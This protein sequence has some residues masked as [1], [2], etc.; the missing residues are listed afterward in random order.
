MNDTSH[1]TSQLLL[2]LG[3]LPSS[4]ESKSPARLSSESLQSALNETLQE[5]LNGLGS[6]IYSGAW[7]PHTTPAGRLISRLRVSARRTSDSAHSSELSGWPTPCAS[8]N[9]D[10]GKWDDPAIQRRMEIGKSIELSM[11]VGVAGWPT[12]KARDHKGGYQGGR[13][14]DGKVSLDTL[15]VAGQLA[16]WPTPIKQDAASS[17]RTTTDG[18]KWQSDHRLSACHT[19]L[20]AA[21]LAGWAT[22]AASN[23]E[24]GGSIRQAM[25]EVRPSGHHPAKPLEHMAQLVNL[26]TVNGPARLTADG[27]MLTGSSAGMESG[28]QLNPEHSRWLMGYPPAWCDCAVTAT[29]SSRKRRPS[30]SKHS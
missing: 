2:P 4:S 1:H 13:I 25:L 14:R 20:D 12:P 9:R 21:R 15:D 3:D 17:A 28:G 8:D 30:S 11:L 18:E 10:R 19:S 26:D 16:G 6:T 24:R 7:K 23:G 22:P 27:Q 5:S 29:Q